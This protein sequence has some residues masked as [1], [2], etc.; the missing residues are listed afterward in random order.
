MKFQSPLVKKSD[1][2]R[3]TLRD[4]IL[5]WLRSICSLF[6][7]WSQSRN[8]TMLNVDLKRTQVFFDSKEKVFAIV[9]MW[10]FPENYFCL[11]A[12]KINELHLHFSKL[13]KIKYKL[14]CLIGIAFSPLWID[15]PLFMLEFSEEEK[16]PSQLVVDLYSLRYVSK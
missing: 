11:G 10:W 2:T 12:P 3:R 9:V 16:N 6:E 7:L 14:F 13:C 1:P 4:D 5:Y 8:R 15:E